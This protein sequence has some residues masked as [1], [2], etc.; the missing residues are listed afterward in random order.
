MA[1][2][3]NLYDCQGDGLSGAKSTA[4]RHI[5]WNVH[6]KKKRARRA[7]SPRSKARRGV[8]RVPKSAGAAFRGGGGPTCAKRSRGVQQ[9]SAPPSDK[10]SLQYS[11]FLARQAAK[12]PESFDSSRLNFPSTL[13]SP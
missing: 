2:K 5:N 4:R 3:C 9:A 11:E 6:S 10:A 8:P 1:P 7:R 13:S 12:R